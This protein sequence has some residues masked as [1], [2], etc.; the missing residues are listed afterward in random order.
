MKEK[1]NNSGEKPT[2]EE[3]SRLLPNN[4]KS[5]RKW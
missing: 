1:E 3:K 4:Y 5:G 2:V